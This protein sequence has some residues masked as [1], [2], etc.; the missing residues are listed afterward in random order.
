MLALEVNSRKIIGYA[1]DR[2]VDMLRYGMELVIRSSRKL[3]FTLIVRMLTLLSHTS[4]E[5]S[6]EED[7]IERLFLTLRITFVSQE[8]PLDSLS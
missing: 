5:S 6:K 2:S 1:I 8:K 3:S 4:K 7:H